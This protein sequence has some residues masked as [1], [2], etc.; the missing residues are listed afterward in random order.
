MKVYK[1][2]GASVKSAEGVKRLTEIIV[3]ENEELLVVVSA[4]GKMT[5]AFEKVIT[6]YFADADWKISLKEIQDF[7]YNMLAAL[8]ENKKHLVY[9]KVEALFDELIQIIEQN[10]SDQH[11]FVYDQVVCFGELLSTTIVS[12]YLNF[13]GKTNQWIDA[14]DCIKTDNFYRSANVDW[15]LSEEAIQS[16][17][18]GD[19]LYITQGFIGAEKTHNFSTTLGREGSDYTAAIF[20]YCLNA[21]SVSI[22]KDVPGVLNADPRYF[23]N[24][25]LLEQISYREAIELAFY[26]ASVIHPKTLQPLQQKEIPLYVRSFEDLEASGTC[27]GKG[28]SISPKVPCYILKPN[29]ILLSLSSL[30]FSFILENHISEVFKMLHEYKLKVNLIQSS[31]ISFTVCVSDIYNNFDKLLEV[32]QKQFRVKYNTNVDLFTVRHFTAD[33]EQEV[34]GDREILVGQ[35]SRETLQLVVR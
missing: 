3:L 15:K 35:Q 10:K 34:A 13:V 25:I 23:E 11:A 9:D 27:V 16:Q 5:N 17:V 14:R 18:K 31:A 24:T 7:H 4:M 12:E 20:A 19:N 8:F 22:W 29:Q 33:T 32:L 28:Q 21:S 6:D 30:D 26:G 2:G 1:F